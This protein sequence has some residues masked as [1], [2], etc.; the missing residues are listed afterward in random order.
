MVSHLAKSSAL[1]TAEI[2]RE[3]FLVTVF[4]SV[5]SNL[6]YSHADV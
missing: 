2:D 1:V 5:E 6:L 3:R 4:F